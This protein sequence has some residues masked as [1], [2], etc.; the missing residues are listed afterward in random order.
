M[1]KRPS[2]F[3]V[4]NVLAPFLGLAFVTLVFAWLTRSTG[5]F[6]TIETWR[7]IAGQSVIVGLAALGMTLIM[8][9]GG[10]DLSV[11]STVALVSVCIALLVSGFEV[12]LPGQSTPWTFRIPVGWAM[13]AGIGI[14]GLCGLFNGTLITRLGVVPFIIT[15]GSL[16]AFRGL[17]KWFS[18]SN[19]VYAY[20]L[21]EERPEWLDRIL[22]TNPD[23]SWLIVAPGVWLW[24]LLAAI[25]AIVLRFT[26]FGRYVYAVGGNERAAYLSGVN[27][28]RV[29][30]LVYSLAGL[31]TGLA[32]V[33]Q[34]LYFHAEGDPTACDGLELS[35]IAAV[36]VGGGSLA[37]GEGTVLGTLI[38]CLIMSV[39]DNG[40]VHAGIPNAARDV[41]IGGIIV[42]AVTLD[43]LRRRRRG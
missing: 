32:G 29:K 13:L 36:V 42:A 28:K 30:L 2:F 20:G 16:K 35:V 18:S 23:P 19:Q 27:V 14:G 9:A 12:P 31:A 4:W 25:L 22:A 17:A 37:G 10:I 24:L 34:F 43:H 3:W 26:V 38:G 39:I 15:L 33:M 8:I 1:S 11:G 41:L 6:F 7:T 40:C 21:S 5:T